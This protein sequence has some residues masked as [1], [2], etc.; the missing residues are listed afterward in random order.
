MSFPRGCGSRGYVWLLW[1]NCLRLA[2]LLVLKIS[3][4]RCHLEGSPQLFLCSSGWAG[5]IHVL[6]NVP[7]IVLVLVSTWTD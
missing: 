3:K 4:Q 7:S 1:L 5:Y 2:R 6:T